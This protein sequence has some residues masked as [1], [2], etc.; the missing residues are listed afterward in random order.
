MTAQFDVYAPGERV[1]IAGGSI[2]AII[3]SVAIYDHGGIQY[4]VVWWHDSVRNSAWISE[5]EF[6]TKAEKTEVGF[7]TG[8]D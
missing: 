8:R 5:P 3:T 4:E 6:A 7:K 2:D 1:T